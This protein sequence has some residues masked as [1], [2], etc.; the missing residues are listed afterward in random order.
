MDAVAASFVAWS[1]P[2]AEHQLDWLAAPIGHVVAIPHR[3]LHC[4]WLI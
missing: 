3:I 4:S 1:P 2:G